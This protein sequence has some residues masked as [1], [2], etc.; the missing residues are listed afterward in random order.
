MGDAFGAGDSI[1][2]VETDKASMEWMQDD[3]VVA[4]HLVALGTEVAVGTPAVALVEDARTS[5]PSNFEAP[6]GPELRRR[7]PPVRGAAGAGRA[8]P[9]RTNAVA[10]PLPRVRGRVVCGRKRV[11]GVAAALPSQLRRQRT[12]PAWPR[13]SDYA[14]SPK[15]RGP[16]AVKT[17]RARCSDGL[18]SSATSCS[19]AARRMPSWLDGVVEQYQRVDINLVV[20][21]GEGL[22]PAPIDVASR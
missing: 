14:I 1:A 8:G 13:L 19:G 16:C 7:R 10:A 12:S 6:A 2:E 5:A 11:K 18:A 17:L 21:V 22:P 20:G 3:G 4:K 15:T 9:G